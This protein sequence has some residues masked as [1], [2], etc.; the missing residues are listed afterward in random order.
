MKN[1]RKTAAEIR[2]IR[3]SGRMLATVLQTLEQRLAPGLTTLELDQ[4]A[5][6]ELGSLGG[7]PAFLGFEGF[8][9]SLC[10]SVNDELIHGIPSPRVLEEGDIVGLDF[11]VTYQGMITDSAVT[12]GV[13]KITAEAKRLLQVTQESLMAGIAV[14][15][16]GAC[17]GDIGAV[18]ES[19]LNKAKLGIVREFCGHGVGH[20]VHEEPTIPN[21]G[22]PGSG[23]KLVTGMTIAI[24]PMAMLGSDAIEIDQDGWTVRTKDGKWGAHFEHTVLVTASGFEILTKL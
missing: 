8:P 14:V 9:A 19:H 22:R 3:E 18:V 17:T 16:D 13:G 10:V 1:R 2:A 11:G 4:M 6:V 5:Q 23:A 12:L 21:Y 20:N 24:E 15:H 7:K